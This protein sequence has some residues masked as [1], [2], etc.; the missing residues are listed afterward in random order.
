MVFSSMRRVV[1]PVGASRTQTSAMFA[2]VNEWSSSWSI[3][4]ESQRIAAQIRSRGVS[5]PATCRWIGLRAIDPP[6]RRLAGIEGTV[7]P[8]LE[9]CRLRARR[10]RVLARALDVHADA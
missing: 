9:T 5:L 1:A 7:A 8:D 2:R 10:L 6:H 4:R 3:E